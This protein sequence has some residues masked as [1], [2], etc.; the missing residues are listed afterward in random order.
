METS[1]SLATPW[2]SWWL[3]LWLENVSQDY[4]ALTNISSCIL[5]LS[6]F[7]E[8]IPCVSLVVLHLVCDRGGYAAGV[9]GPLLH[10]LPGGLL[11]DQQGVVDLPHHGQHQAPQD[12]WESQP[13]GQYLVVVCLQVCREWGARGGTKEVQLAPAQEDEGGGGEDQGEMGRGKETGAI[14]QPRGGYWIVFK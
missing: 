7:K 10:R 3:S 14:C 5:R 13:H 11:G 12:I 4:R 2:S 8:E 1:S 6:T 9:Q